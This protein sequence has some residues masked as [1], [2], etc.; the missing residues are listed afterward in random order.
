MLGYDG[1]GGGGHWSGGLGGGR[2]PVGQHLNLIGAK[3]MA[4]QKRQGP[5]WEWW[6]T[7]SRG[8]FSCFSPQFSYQVRGAWASHT[9]LTPELPAQLMN[10]ESTVAKYL[11]RPQEAEDIALRKMVH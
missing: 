1:V 8:G 4:L 11:P 10:C 6:M 5:D 3:K 7:E 9:L 2:G